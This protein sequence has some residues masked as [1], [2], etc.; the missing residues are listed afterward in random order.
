MAKFMMHSL[1]IYFYQNGN[2]IIKAYNRHY[3]SN[4]SVQQKSSTGKCRVSVHEDQKSHH[5]LPE[6]AFISTL[7]IFFNIA[8][9]SRN[10]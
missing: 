8:A 3:C 10:F 2:I 7:G 4:V 1:K 6:V 5:A 9:P